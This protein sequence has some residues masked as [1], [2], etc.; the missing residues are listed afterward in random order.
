VLAFL[1][2]LQL[3]HLCHRFESNGVDGE[4]LL[5]LS[6]EDLKDDLEITDP[7]QLAQISAAIVALQKYTPRLVGLHL[8]S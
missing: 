8:I 3:G 4:Q 1:V 5:D 2:Q 7:Q 6:N